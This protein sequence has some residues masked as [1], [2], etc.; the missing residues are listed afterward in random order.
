MI[1]RRDAL[2]LGAAGITAAAAA[3][4]TRLVAANG[5]CSA[6]GLCR[7][8]FDERDGECRV[9]AREIERRGVATSGIRNDVAALWYQDL[10]TQLRV[11]RLPFAGL[12]D[13][14][15]LFCFEELARDVGMKVRYRVDRVLE[16]E[17]RVRHEIHGAPVA[18][19]AARNIGADENFGR[20]MAQ[21]AIEFDGRLAGSMAAQ[22]RT[23]PFGPRNGTALVAWI[24]A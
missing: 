2:K 10:R 14:A 23:G 13:R 8:V 24:I 21:L 16:Q 11:T 19:E 17:G 3:V 6:G 22:R 4:S 12:T 1:N 18:V 9:F 15:A 20:A 5:L 7:A